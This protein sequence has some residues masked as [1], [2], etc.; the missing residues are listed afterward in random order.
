MVWKMGFSRRALAAVGVAL[1][2]VACTGAWTPSVAVEPSSGL[3]GYVRQIA[4]DFLHLPSWENLEIMA[5]G[6]GLTVVSH[7]YDAET[8]ERMSGSHQV[9]TFFDPGQWI[10]SAAYLVPATFVMYGVGRGSDHPRVSSLAGELFR[11]EILSQ[12][13]THAIKFTAQRTRPDG[14]KYSFPSGHA[15]ATFAIAVTLQRR[16]GW[17]AGAPAYVVASYVA[18]SRLS[19]RKHYA[20]DVVFGVALGVASGRT[21]TRDVGPTRLSLAAAPVSAGAG[22]AFKVRSRR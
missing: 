6:G 2:L 17:K 21:V 20:S 4:G 11:A 15:S 7:Q 13:V 3:S 16:L 5:A 18:V 1:D 8:V 12:A 14:T 9:E 19:E 10:G 22:F